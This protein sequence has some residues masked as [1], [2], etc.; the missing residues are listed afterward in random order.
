MPYLLFL[1]LGQDLF[2]GGNYFRTEKNIAFQL[3]L[4]P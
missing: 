2:S 3:Y 4:S 1:L